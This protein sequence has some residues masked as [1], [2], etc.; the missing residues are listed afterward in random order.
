MLT[1]TR[2]L[3]QVR[4]LSL[5][6]KSIGSN[7]GVTL[8]VSPDIDMVKEHFSYNFANVV[9]ELCASV[10]FLLG[11]S[12]IAIYDWLVALGVWVSAKIGLHQPG[13]EQGGPST[14]ASRPSQTAPLSSL[15]PA[16]ST[17]SP[18]GPGPSQSG[19]LAGERKRRVSLVVPDHESS[20]YS[21]RAEIM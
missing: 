14:P 16:R 17:G 18:S 7:Y 20:P 15:P 11:L 3:L 12:A 10:S 1:A 5:G 2:R 13:R 9:S 21:H 19:G 8:T 4:I 6:S